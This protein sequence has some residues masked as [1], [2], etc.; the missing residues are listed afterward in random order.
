MLR[1]K[2]FDPKTTWYYKNK[3]MN[4]NKEEECTNNNKEEELVF[5]NENNKQKI[6]CESSQSSTNSDDDSNSELKKMIEIECKECNAIDYILLDDKENWKC[7]YCGCLLYN[8]T[9]DEE[10][11]LNERKR[12]IFAVNN[13]ESESSSST[14]CTK[15]VNELFNEIGRLIK[16]TKK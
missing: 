4:Q 13:D 7:S 15:S 12:N 10:M 16:R 2:L 11:P 6:I 8:Y 9:H 1:Y 14:S 3:I 5:V